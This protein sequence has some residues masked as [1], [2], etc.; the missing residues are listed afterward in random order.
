M[1]YGQLHAAAV[2]SVAPVSSSRSTDFDAVTKSRKQ[3]ISRSQTSDKKRL[4]VY[5]I[6]VKK[7]FIIN[8]LVINQSTRVDKITVRT[9]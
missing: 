2:A 9:L 5:Y 3:K 6:S 4:D 8:Q 1:V 7:F